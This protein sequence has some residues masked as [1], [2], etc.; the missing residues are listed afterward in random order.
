MR[1]INDMIGQ[2]RFGAK[3]VAAT[4]PIAARPAL[5]LIHSPYTLEMIKKSVD[6]FIMKISH[7]GLRNDA[8]REA[9]RDPR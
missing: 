9:I 7:M 4:A 6:C 5:R 1:K 8:L 2:V 3:L